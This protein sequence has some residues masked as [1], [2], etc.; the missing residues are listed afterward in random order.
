MQSNN[1]SEEVVIKSI[2]ANEFFYGLLIALLIVIIAKLYLILKNRRPNPAIAYEIKHLL[3]KYFIYYRY[4]SQKRKII[5]EERVFRFIREKD[6]VPRNFREVTAEMKILIAAT[7]VQIT[8]GL[9][10]ITLH[11]F[12]RVIIYPD[13]YY[14]TITG[15]YH[16][17]EVNPR[18]QSIVLSWKS[19][20]EG[21]MNP[22]DSLNLGLHEMAHALELENLIENGESN[23]LSATLLAQW[24]QVVESVMEE[25]E[26]GN[27]TFFR[28]YAAHN[29]QEFF[30]V[31]IENFFERPEAFY[32]QYPAIYNTMV[33]L[34]NQNPLELGLTDNDSIYL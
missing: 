13:A 15:Q 23:F 20:V 24:K 4:L 7:A 8:F 6:F 30:A 25:I 17:G 11:H 26:S 1:R 9:P 34:L 31:A 2:V 5:F 14:S 29:R 33:A 32:S 27:N 19:F 12:K 16:K 21:F 3:N 18:A 28:E 10:E 22:D